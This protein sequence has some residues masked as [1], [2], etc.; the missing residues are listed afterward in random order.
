MI[1]VA[2]FWRWAISCSGSLGNGVGFTECSDMME[3]TTGLVSL[4]I[5]RNYLRGQ[6]RE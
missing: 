6:A 1:L 2:R 4:N 5:V 3:E